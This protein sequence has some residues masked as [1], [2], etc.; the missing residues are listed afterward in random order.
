MQFS[1][2]LIPEAGLKHV[3]MLSCQ[4]GTAPHS[5]LLAACTQFREELGV[6]EETAKILVLPEAAAATADAMEVESVAGGAPHGGGAAGAFGA[7]GGAPAAGGAEGA[8]AGAEA[9][10]A[11][12]GKAPGGAG[13]SHAAARYRPY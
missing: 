11:A 12:Y 7:A 2:V 5:A 9:G 13:A 10:K 4:E 8:G 6:E 3:A 1:K